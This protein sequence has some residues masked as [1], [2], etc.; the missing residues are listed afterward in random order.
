ME[1]YLKKEYLKNWYLENKEKHLETVK[2]KIMCEVCNKMVIK[3]HFNR[4]VRTNIHKKNMNKPTLSSTILDKYNK[5]M[6]L[7]K[8]MLN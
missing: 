5:V 6:K 3:C 7:S 4:H 8:D 1:N 2:E